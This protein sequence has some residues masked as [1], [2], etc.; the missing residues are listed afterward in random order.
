MAILVRP[1]MQTLI[2][3]NDPDVNLHPNRVP[4]VVLDKIFVG[5]SWKFRVEFRDGTVGVIRIA[6]K[7]RCEFAPGDQALVSWVPD[8]GVVLPAA[9]ERAR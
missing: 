4:C 5:A 1:E 7:L 2:A 8:T 9:A 6:E 3:E